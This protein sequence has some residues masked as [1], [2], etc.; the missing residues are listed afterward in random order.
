MHQ[1]KATINLSSASETLLNPLWDRAI[2]QTVLNATLSMMDD[3]HSDEI[4]AG[5][6][7]F[8]GERPVRHCSTDLRFKY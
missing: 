5:V 6:A 2:L 3:V 8:L 4:V 7:R 1:D